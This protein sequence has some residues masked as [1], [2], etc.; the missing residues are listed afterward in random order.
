[1]TP[2]SVSFWSWNPRP[3]PNENFASPSRPK[4]CVMLP[5]IGTLMSTCASGMSTSTRPLGCSVNAKVPPI[6]RTPAALIVT[7]PV[8]RLRVRAGRERHRHGIGSRRTAIGIR[9][10]TARPVWLILIV[11]MPSIVSPSSP[12]SCA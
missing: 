1:M 5:L 12:T 9:S 4:T 8:H 3:P 11:T 6:V 2:F 7:L 10:M